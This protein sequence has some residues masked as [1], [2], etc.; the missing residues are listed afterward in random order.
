[1]IHSAAYVLRSVLIALSQVTAPSSQ[2]SW[3][4]FV[5]NEPNLPDDCVTLYNTL[6][7]DDGRA[8]IDGKV[9][10]HKGIQVRV[11][12]LDE[13]T[14]WN[15]IMELQVAVAE[16]IRN[17]SVTIDSESYLVQA[18]TR[19]QDPTPIGTEQTSKRLLFTMNCTMSYKQL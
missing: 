16:H 3:P 9:F 11:R 12:S 10:K 6:G 15:K 14:G 17:Y 4:A 5:S 13:P 19:I 2:T 18:V 7:T 1:M 8:M